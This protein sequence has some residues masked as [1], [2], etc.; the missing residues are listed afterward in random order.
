MEPQSSVATA[1]DPVDRNLPQVGDGEG[2]HVSAQKHWV[3]DALA[4]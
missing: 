2:V 1:S 4:R 3:G